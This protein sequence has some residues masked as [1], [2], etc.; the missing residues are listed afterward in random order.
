MKCVII[1]DEPLAIKILKGYVEKV[2]LLKLEATFTNPF[3]AW[4]H[5]AKNQVDLIFLDINMPG[6]TGLQ[7]VQTLS[8]INTKII[9]T[10]AYS[11]YALEG[12]NLDIVDYLLKPIGFDRFL[13]A[14]NKAQRTAAGPIASTPDKS[15]QVIED[16]LL[17][18][19]EHRLIKVFYK[20]IWYIEGY[21]DYVKI[22]TDEDRPL[23][24]LKSMKSM[25]ELLS[26]QGF[27]RIHK[28]YLVSI[29]KIK[30]IRN[31]KVKLKEKFLTISDTYKD[32][33]SERVLKGK[34]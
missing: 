2:P 4:E 18:K 30:E 28:S 8:G 3:K 22:Y 1:D 6:L 19:S 23:L 21:K 9:F 24:T 32:S 34:V 16:Y 27:V 12:F 33:F 26:E 13:K 14:V 31:G 20:D 15:A 17:V 25:E 29:S 7:L 11:E 5:L 10:T